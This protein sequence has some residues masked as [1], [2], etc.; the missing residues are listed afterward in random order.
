M[1]REYDFSKYAISPVAALLPSEG[2][3]LN[4][5][6][7]VACDQYTS[8]PEYWREAE[9]LI[10]GSPSTLN[11]IYPEAMLGD[12][13]ARIE[14]INAAMNDYIGGGV[15]A[16]EVE[17]FILVE[18]SL[19]AGKRIGLVA[20]FD[21]DKYDYASGAQSMIRA[22]EGTILER[23]PPR[24][25]IRKDA[26]LEVPHVM[27]LTDDPERSLIEPLYA[28]RDSYRLLYDFELMKGGGHIRG[29]LVDGRAQG[30]MLAALEG[31]LKRSGGLL[32]A[33]GDGNHS[34]A[35]A[36]TCW[37]DIKG[38]F[39]EFGR[40]YHPA[41]YAMAELV[42]VHDPA[43]TFEPI[44]RVLSG[45]NTQEL[46]ADFGGW[47]EGRD[48]RL[49]A[50]AG[51]GMF[52]YVDRFGRIPMN[53]EG[54]DGPLPLSALQEFLDLFLAAHPGVE[55]DYVHGEDVVS[56]LVGPDSC[57]FIMRPMDKSSLFEGVRREGSLPRKAFSM[58]EAHEKRFYLESRKIRKDN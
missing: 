30:D 35:T 51:E 31:L 21:L 50:A 37:E 20:A 56:E 6:A 43:L 38:S 5:W 44:H 16:P 45:L 36:K 39:D 17:G 18:R 2:I 9:E 46:M 1:K 47:L 7:V 23:I 57:G 29:W 54:Y 58:G 48:L 41:R 24:V 3:S 28:A 25:K 32:F 55:I 22:T 11:M 40:A 42:N 8:Q 14:S 19:S 13:D 34:L 53:M 26:P 49:R 52:T 33:V 27:M 4:K 15:F 10:G 12:G